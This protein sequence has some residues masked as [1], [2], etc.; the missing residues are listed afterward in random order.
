MIKLFPTG[1]LM[2]ALTAG[3]VA[4]QTVTTPQA[5]QPVA[6]TTTAMPPTITVPE[7]YIAEKVVFSA[8][9]LDGVTVYDAT[10]ERIGEVHVLVFANASTSVAGTDA[11]PLARTANPAHDATTPPPMAAPDGVAST[12][13]AV[14]G[15][16]KV[17]G[18]KIG[19]VGHDA[20]SASRT[21][22]ATPPAQSADAMTIERGA[23]TQAVIDVGG[24][25]GMGEHRVAIPVEELI[26]YRKDNEFA[27]DA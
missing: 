10:G 18:D 1:I 16:A 13:P 5:V 12:D 17:E 15:T 24:F 26:A 27:E 3:A 23:I 20:T 7:G 4:A 21:E 2:L 22:A 8:E 6:T 9:N 14:S 11:T 19:N 25:L